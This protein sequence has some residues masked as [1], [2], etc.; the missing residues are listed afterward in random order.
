MELLAAAA[1][2]RK[3]A[4]PVP[5]SG[6]LRE[7]DLVNVSGSSARRGVLVGTQGE[8]HFLFSD[9]RKWGGDPETVKRSSCR[10]LTAKEVAKSAGEWLSKLEAVL[11]SAKDASAQ[12]QEEGPDSSKLKGAMRALRDKLTAMESEHGADPASA[13]LL[14]LAHNSAVLDRGAWLMTPPAPPAESEQ[15]EEENAR[16]DGAGGTTVALQRLLRHL[17]ARLPD[18]RLLE[19]MEQQKKAVDVAIS[20]AAA[21]DLVAGGGGE[22][23]VAAGR[24]DSEGGQAEGAEAQLESEKL[25]LRL[26]EEE[27][28]G[29]VTE[30]NTVY[31]GAMAKAT[32]DLA[33]SCVA[34]L[35]EHVTA[36]V[37][38]SEEMT[39][40]F[41]QKQ[42][43]EAEDT[44]GRKGARKRLSNA[45]ASKRETKRDSV[46]EDEARHADAQGPEEATTNTEYAA[47]YGFP[48]G[49]MVRVKS[50]G[51]HKA[52]WNGTLCKVDELQRDPQIPVSRAEEWLYLCSVVHEWPQ[53]S[54]PD[55]DASSVRVKGA[56][57]ELDSVYRARLTQDL[58]PLTIPGSV[59]RQ[60]EESAPKSREKSPEPKSRAKSPEPKPRAKSPRQ[61]IEGAGAVQKKAKERQ[62]S[63]EPLPMSLPKSR[64]GSPACREK[65]PEEDGEEEDAEEQSSKGPKYF[66]TREN[67]T[68]RNIAQWCGIA[69]KQTLVDLNL[70]K[71]PA[72]TAASKLRKGTTLLLPGDVTAETMTNKKVARCL[73]SEAQVWEQQEK[74]PANHPCKLPAKSPAKKAKEDAPARSEKRKS[75]EL[76]KSQE[77]RSKNAR[78]S[79]PS[80]RR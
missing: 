76:L 1:S 75:E 31:S 38:K 73:L 57:L 54:D 47:A 80:P 10:R 4:Q 52:S 44:P 48:E 30:F 43:E 79:N 12:R 55:P 50:L 29:K 62:Q 14:R 6:E 3:T 51:K 24:D 19:L 15:A 46:T 13:P 25:A 56:N 36:V 8:R 64:E 21:L 72:L 53:G 69:D 65:S 63:E 22:A 61:Q 28:E 11:D 32:R 42:G 59:P 70:D 68:C 41:K 74:L 33:E 78:H 20:D 5:G 77:R 9:A 39:A 35:H 66:L 49:S 67:D 58:T 16:G 45:T 71:Y 27:L 7:G 23:S 37:N 17:T 40:S 26:L 34:S 18:T 2:S 60:S